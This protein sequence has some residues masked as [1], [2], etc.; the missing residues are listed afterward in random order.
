MGQQNF[1]RKI[2]HPLDLILKLGI[3]SFTIFLLPCYTSAQSSKNCSAGN[4]YDSSTDKCRACPKACLTCTS[5]TTCTSCSSGFYQSSQTTCSSCPSLCQECSSPFSCSSC[6]SGSFFSQNTC[7]ACSSNCESCTGSSSQQCTKCRA[8]F[9][10]ESSGC[11]A[12]GIGCE[13]CKTSANGRTCDKCYGGYNIQDDR[14]CKAILSSF[15]VIAIMGIIFGA[16]CCVTSACSGIY[17]CFCRKT[18]TMK[19]GSNMSHNRSSAYNDRSFNMQDQS[20]MSVHYPPHQY[21]PGGH[22]MYQVSH[23]SLAPI[24]MAMVPMH[25]NPVLVPQQQAIILTPRTN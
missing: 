11:A 19:R 9:V 15:S 7:T 4:Y 24:Q 23:H 6:K 25:Q 8:G 2:G 16:I 3:I 5:P 18:P 1:D 10:L 20:M 21:P 22:S 17:C 14:T 13:V 12:C